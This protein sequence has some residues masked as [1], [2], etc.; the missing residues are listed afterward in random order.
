[1]SNLHIIDHP[2]IQHKLTIMREIQTGPKE[3]RELLSD[4][5]NSF[6][7]SN[8]LNIA[9]NADMVLHL[10][11][12]IRDIEDLKSALTCPFYYVSGNC[13]FG[14]VY[15]RVIEVENRKI[16]MTHGNNYD[17]KYSLSR[18]K[19]KAKQL[20][21]DI[22]LYGHTHIPDITIEDNIWFINPGSLT[23]P[24]EDKQ[25]TYCIL[26]LSGGKIYPQ[27]MKY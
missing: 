14:N 22:A 2:L 8:F 21:A 17:V 3:F 18:L 20:G 23:R 11:D 26:T 13:D 12:G 6:G 10:G 19:Q 7:F 16:F 25:P 1:M 15:E 5:H 4:S 9:Q 24:R 27:L